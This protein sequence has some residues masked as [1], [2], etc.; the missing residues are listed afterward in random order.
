MSLD[1]EYPEVFARFYNV[2]YDHI[3]KEAD[4]SYYLRKI[5]VAKGRFLKSVLEQDVSSHR[6][7]AKE[8][9]FTELIS[10]RQ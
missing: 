9:I 1:Y 10:V 4:H 5:K 8:P 6:L 3:R 2:I 7:W